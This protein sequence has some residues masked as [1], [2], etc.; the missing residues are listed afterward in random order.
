MPGWT[1]LTK[2]SWLQFRPPTE[3]M[4]DANKIGVAAAATAQRADEAAMQ[5]RQQ[6]A[7]RLDRH[8][9]LKEEYMYRSDLQGNSELDALLQKLQMKLN[10]GSP[11]DFWDGE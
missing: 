8:R 2:L 7:G 10:G 1:D 6:T 11:G 3:I 9:L 5:D 4:L